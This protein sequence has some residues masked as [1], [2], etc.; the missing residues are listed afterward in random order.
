MSSWFQADTYQGFSKRYHKSI[1]VKVYQS[2]RGA[3]LAVKKKLRH[4]GFEA[5]FYV[6]VHGR[7]LAKIQKFKTDKIW[8]PIIPLPLD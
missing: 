5:T 2:Y 6:V 3:K 4:F 7:I 8:A 1:L